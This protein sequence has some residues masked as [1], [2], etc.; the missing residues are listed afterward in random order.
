M[1][2]FVLVACVFEENKNNFLQSVNNSVIA[3][4]IINSM[5]PE[6]DKRE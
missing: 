1:I 4:Q 6:C 5:V 2:L 3:H